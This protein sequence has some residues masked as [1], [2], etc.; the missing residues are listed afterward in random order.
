[1][2]TAK[3]FM[4]QLKLFCLL[5]FF[6][7]FHG[8]SQP[9]WKFHLAFEDATGSRDTIWFIWD[10]TATIYGVDSHL[11]E[12]ISGMDYSAFNAW[13]FL[14]NGDTS[15]VN[16]YPY[17]IGHQFSIEAIN[18]ELPIKYQWDSSLFHADWLPPEPVG[19][20]NDA[21]I[22][23][24]Y[25]FFV[26]NTGS[27]YFDLTLDNNAIAPDSLVVGDENENPWFWQPEHHF[28]LGIGLAQNPSVFT[29]EVKSLTSEVI[30]YPNPVRSLLSIKTELKIKNIQIIDSKGKCL[31]KYEYLATP[32]TIDVSCFDPGVYIIKFNTNPKNYHYEK[33][34]KIP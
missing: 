3:T 32:K 2:G 6:F 25:F 12:G 30:L 31:H 24:D 8:Y 26:N 34:I 7:S 19:W 14:P 1:M 23:S 21:W 18:F 10:T 16:A 29:S 9:Q 27:H 4:L 22:G 33:F 20:V 15:K 13:L 17:N 28:P 5:L 11:G